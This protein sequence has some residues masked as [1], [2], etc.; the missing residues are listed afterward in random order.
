MCTS[1][2]CRYV[3]RF[4]GLQATLAGCE[5]S[6]VPTDVAR[7]VAEFW[8]SSDNA[9]GAS[10]TDAAVRV[11]GDP[12]MAVVVAVDDPQGVLRCTRTV[13]LFHPR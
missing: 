8:S 7:K 10:E 4:Q 3:R 5:G 13:P 9:D 11:C 2:I 12:P 6:V 1:H